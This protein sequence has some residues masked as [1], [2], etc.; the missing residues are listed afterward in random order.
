MDMAEPEEELMVERDI[1]RNRLA[2]P[3]PPSAMEPLISI[4]ENDPLPGMN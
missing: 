4:G 2:D 3:A 1:V